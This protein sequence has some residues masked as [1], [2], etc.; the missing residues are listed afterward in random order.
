MLPLYYRGM[1]FL[2]GLILAGGIA[3]PPAFS[4]GSPVSIEAEL[5]ARLEADAGAL[6]DQILG[7]GRAK[8]FIK[9]QGESSE[10]SV[11]P[12]GM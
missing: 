1:A 8:V 4:A 10:R 2:A 9:L 6:L 7:P 5:A 11:M 12:T 3:V